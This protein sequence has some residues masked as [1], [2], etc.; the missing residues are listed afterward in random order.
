MSPRAKGLVVLL[1]LVTL[2]GGAIALRTLLFERVS[3]T[4]IAGFTGEAAVNPYLAL[5]RLLTLAGVDTTSARG[6]VRLPPRSGLL[7][8]APPRRSLG[9]AGAT[10]LLDWAAD[11][12]HLVIV[13]AP[14]G[15]AL[16]DP[17]L[18]PLDIVLHG[19]SPTEAQIEEAGLIETG[20]GEGAEDALADLGS[21]AI[22]YVGDAEPLMRVGRLGATTLLRLP[23]GRGAVTVLADASFLTNEELGEGDNAL[24]AWEALVHGELPASASLIYRDRRPAP[25]ALLAGRAA[26][27]VIALVA[28]VTAWLWKAAARFGPLLPAGGPDRRSL[29]EHVRAAGAWQWGCGAQGALIDAVRGALRRELRRGRHD[30]FKEAA[31]AA[32]ES[33][34]A[35]VELVGGALAERAPKDRQDFVRVVRTLEE[36][37]RSTR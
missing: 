26:P 35:D 19:L 1:V 2:L 33:S 28:L 16:Q 3:E 14:T 34:G 13:P 5:E 20:S 11:G 24:R 22:R 4:R 6:F 25:W 30:S 15:E 9:R 27:I 36:L 18:E 31:L 12:G 23:H 29:A 17:L 32:A 8:V 10:R 21:L 7:L 37:R